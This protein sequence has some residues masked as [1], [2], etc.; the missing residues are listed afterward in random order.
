MGELALFVGTLVAGVGMLEDEIK[1]VEGG[2]PVMWI[3]NLT[4]FPVLSESRTVNRASATTSIPRTFGNSV[5]TD[6]IDARKLVRF[7]AKGLLSFVTVPERDQEEV[8]D[9]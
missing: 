3:T 4:H 6:R 5:K 9:H 2:N 7:Y 1:K 8:R